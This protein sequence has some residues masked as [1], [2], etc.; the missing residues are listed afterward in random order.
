[1]RCQQFEGVRHIVAAYPQ[2]ERGKHQRATLSVACQRAVDPKEA[3]LEHK[4]TRRDS[5]PIKRLL[6]ARRW[7]SWQSGRSL[8]RV[9]VVL[10][11]TEIGKLPA[12]AF[13]NV[14]LNVNGALNASN[15]NIMRQGDCARI[16]E[17]I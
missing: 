10:R 17:R 4:K 7:I 13:F 5:V 12:R 3:S 11:K 14:F 9:A 16:C 1:M 15:R 8:T 6:S 2:S